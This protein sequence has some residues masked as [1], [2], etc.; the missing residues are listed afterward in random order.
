LRSIPGTERGSRIR[1]LKER[2]LEVEAELRAIGQGHKARN[3][4]IGTS[5]GVS[6]AA[7]AFAPSIGAVAIGAAIAALAGGHS[8]LAKSAEDEEK[9]RS[10]PAFV[11]VQAKELLEHR[12]G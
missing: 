8:H 9:L 6:L 4:V 7:F 5:I 3:I 1:E 10:V 11:L 12:V 2:A